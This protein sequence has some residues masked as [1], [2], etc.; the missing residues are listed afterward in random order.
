MS[1]IR[2]QLAIA[3]DAKL[4]ALAKAINVSLCIYHSQTLVLLFIEHFLLHQH[5]RPIGGYIK[6][7][8]KVELGGQRPQGKKVVWFSKVMFV[9]FQNGQ[10]SKLTNVPDIKSYIALW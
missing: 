3:G 7:S 4:F 8:D 9:D 6:C 10:W 1:I 5:E 2:Q